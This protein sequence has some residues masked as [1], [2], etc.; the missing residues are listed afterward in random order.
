MLLQDNAKGLKPCP[1]CKS[2]DIRIACVVY[3]KRRLFF[4]ECSCCQ[5]CGGT[6]PTRL[7]A[8]LAWNLKRRGAHDQ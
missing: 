5:W 8:K 4:G 3:R 7:W 2:A 6:R 1:Y